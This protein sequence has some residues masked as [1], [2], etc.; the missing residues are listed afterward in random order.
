[1][2]RPISANCVKTVLRHVWKND[3]E[4]ADDAGYTPLYRDLYLIR[5]ETIERVFADAKEKHGT[6]YTL[7]RGLAQVSKC[8]GLEFV[9][10]N[11]KKLDGRKAKRQS[12]LAFPLFSTCTYLLCFAACLDLSQAGRFFDGL[13]RRSFSYAVP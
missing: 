8:V 12:R 7:D 3:E 10:M 13:K 1:M 11:L 9:T 2:K 4:L 6:R 5:K